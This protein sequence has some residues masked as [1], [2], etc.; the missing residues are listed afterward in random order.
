MHVQV[1]GYLL[2]SIAVFLCSINDLFISLSLDQ[3]HILRKYP[4]SLSPRLPFAAEAECQAARPDPIDF[5]NTS[6]SCKL[7][8]ASCLLEPQNSSVAE[9]VIQTAG[10]PGL[11]K[12]IQ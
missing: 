4:V 3:K 2:L 8:R 9:K 12:S 5:V 1:N 7:A 11:S 10:R 6:S